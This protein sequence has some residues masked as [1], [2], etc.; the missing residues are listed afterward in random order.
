VSLRNSIETADDARRTLRIVLAGAYDQLD[1][2]IEAVMTFKMDLHTEFKAMDEKL[3]RMIEGGPAPAITEAV[4][5]EE[6]KE[7]EKA[8]EPEKAKEEADVKAAD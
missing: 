6:T 8:A 5:P 4:A 3:E 2:V 7:P 1:A